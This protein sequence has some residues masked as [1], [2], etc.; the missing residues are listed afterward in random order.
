MDSGTGEEWGEDPGWRLNWRVFLLVLPQLQIRYLRRA[1][2]DA[3][4]MLRSLYLSFL[5]SLVLYG[6]VLSFITPFRGDD[7][8][9]SW[10]IFIGALTIFNL[11]LVRRLERQLSCDSDA[12]LVGAYRTRFF[13]RI[14][15]A[16]SIVLFG[17]VAASVTKSTWVYFAAV[18]L[19]VPG[20]LRAA[21]T[22]AALSRDQDELTAQG[23][24]RSLVAA[25]RQRPMG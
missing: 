20:F 17:F 6:V 5:T 12:S 9:L 18:F 16:E 10:L 1:G 24:G 25:F 13:L 11:L 22:R 3:L 4:V 14:A 7:A 8:A 15:L 21:P 19:S 2:G 23:C